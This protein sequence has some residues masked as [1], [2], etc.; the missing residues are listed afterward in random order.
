M[1]GLLDE[2]AAPD[3]EAAAEAGV[4]GVACGAVR[5]RGES[6][7]RFRERCTLLVETLSDENLVLRWGRMERENQQKAALECWMKWKERLDRMA[8]SRDFFFLGT[9]EGHTHLREK[10]GRTISASDGALVKYDDA[11][12]RE[13]F[14]RALDKSEAVE[15]MLP[16]R[17]ILMDWDGEIEYPEEIND[18]FSFMHEGFADQGGATII[19]VQN[20]LAAQVEEVDLGDAE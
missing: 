13:V 19:E 11:V 7:R 15:K 9:E 20:E 14:R 8:C 1:R 16:P 6:F 10:L 2:G 12:S 4:L 17:Q 5:V 18:D 3:L